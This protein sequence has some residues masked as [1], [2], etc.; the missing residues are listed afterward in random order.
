MLKG[1]HYVGLI[2]IGIAIGLFILSNFNFCIPCE[3]WDALNPFCYFAYWGCLAWAGMFGI[4][5][6]IMAII[7]FIIGM[8]RLIRK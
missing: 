4:V 1:K 2:F 7:L 5:M 3:G 6:K 8:L